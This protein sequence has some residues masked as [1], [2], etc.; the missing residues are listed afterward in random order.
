MRGLGTIYNVAGILLGGAAGLLFGRW[1]R[2]RMQESLMRVIGVCVLF[3]GI[4]G[5]LEEMLSVTQSGLQSGG[6]M[7]LIAS[8]SLG[9]LLGEL[10][11]LEDKFDRFGEYL[12]RKTRS[13]GDASFVDGFVTASLTVCIGAMA[14]VGAIR[15][16]M[17]GDHSVLLAKAVLD[18]I[19][20][21]LMAVSMGKGCLFSAI[22]VAVFQGLLTLAAGWIAPIMT[23][24]AL[25][26]LS[27]V[28]SVLIFCVGV[29]L[30]WE[31][32]F[33]VANMLP[34]IVFAVVYG[35]FA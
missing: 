1:I 20:V 15:D 6:T 9:T 4:A 29:N 23:A 35:L 17:F 32:R 3:L 30:I 16:G 5:C 28:G 34:S 26:N 2:P 21:A 14:V 10:L 13:E 7:M 24:P 19:I 25:S 22:P 11:D 18:L 33:R 31:K 12:K 27:L 8:V